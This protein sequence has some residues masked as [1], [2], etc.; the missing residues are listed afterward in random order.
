L[1]DLVERHEVN[2][3]LMLLLSSGVL[4]LAEGFALITGVTWLHR[5]SIPIGS[6]LREHTPFAIRSMIAFESDDPYDIVVTL[7]ARTVA[8]W[9]SKG[10]IGFRMEGV[11]F[12]PLSG[13][14][15]TCTGILQAL[16]T[17]QGTELRMHR[18]LRFTPALLLL[19]FFVGFAYETGA[20]F[21]H[22][23]MIA[24]VVFMG[25]L[26]LGLVIYHYRAIGTVYQVITASAVAHASQYGSTRPSKV[27]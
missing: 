8:F 9:R 6:V 22:P 4:L 7:D 24:A 27:V 10:R 23:V 3:M 16:S 2:L 11:F 18:R 25:G 5:L 15:I 13:I 21:L 17:N 14:G 26:Y 20:P 12:R 1:V 19:A